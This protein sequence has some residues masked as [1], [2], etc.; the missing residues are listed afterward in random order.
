MENERSGS[1]EKMG[2]EVTRDGDI[3]QAV[4]EWLLRK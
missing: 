3:D 4:R 1:R 2:R